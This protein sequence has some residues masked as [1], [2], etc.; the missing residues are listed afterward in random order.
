MSHG[1]E[2]TSLGI[3]ILMQCS[4][5]DTSENQDDLESEIRI[6]ALCE[7]VCKSVGTV[8]RRLVHQLL[9]LPVMRHHV[10]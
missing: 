3:P 9:I 2:Y 4:W 5:G 8:A 6:D 7:G 10:Y 1:V